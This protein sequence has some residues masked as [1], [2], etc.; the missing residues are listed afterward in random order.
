[1]LR[2]HGCL[3][4]RTWSSIGE[5]ALLLAFFFLLA[6]LMAYASYHNR[7]HFL[8]RHFCPESKYQQILDG[9]TNFVLTSVVPRGWR[10]LTLVIP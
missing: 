3:S 10:L 8:N 6:M 1:M 4:C 5:P 9:L 7:Q 2:F